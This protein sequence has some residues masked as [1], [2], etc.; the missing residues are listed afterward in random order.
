MIALVLLPIRMI[1][2]A[3]SVMRAEGDEEIAAPPPTRPNFPAANTEPDYSAYENAT[4]PPAP[5]NLY[6]IVAE[7]GSSETFEDAR[8]KSFFKKDF[9]FS[10]NF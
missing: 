3:A 1:L 2:C 6:E 10:K 8:Y 4:A 5:D 9:E 7:Y